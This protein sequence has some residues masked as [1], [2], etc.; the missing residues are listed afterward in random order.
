M[1]KWLN[2]HWLAFFR[3]SRC[4]T[5]TL[6]V[7]RLT[8]LLLL[9]FS[10]AVS[11][12]GLSQTVSFTGKNVSLPSVFSV[13]KQQ[14]G[15]FVVYNPSWLSLAKPVSLS[16]K[17]LPLTDFLRLALSEQPFDFSIENTTIILSRKSSDRQL[18]NERFDLKDSTVTVSGRVTD[19][20]GIPLAGANVTVRGT[21]KGTTTNLKG[22]FVIKDV[23]GNST[24]EISFVEYESQIIPVKDKTFL[25]VSLQTKIT[26]MQEVV[27][28]KGYYTET[29][30][31]STGNVASVKANDKETT[32]E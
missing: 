22:E 9:S 26:S 17:N 15:F 11:A 2:Y 10:V 23:N 14:T 5:K 32:S 13:I 7:M 24:L 6:R 19:E 28:N 18:K 25:D 30:R 31:F 1:Q 21:N 3:H 27:I 4:I 20:Q 29:K 12:N 8:A 16:A